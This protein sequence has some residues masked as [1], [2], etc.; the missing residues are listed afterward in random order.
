MLTAIPQGGNEFSVYRDE[1]F[2]GRIEVED[3]EDD[4]AVEEAVRK[5]AG[6]D[7]EEYLAPF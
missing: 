2:L 6:S 5:L 3:W 4:E 1:Q 7:D